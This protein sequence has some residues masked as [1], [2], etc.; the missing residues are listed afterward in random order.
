MLWQLNNGKQTQLSHSDANF[1]TCRF[2]VQLYEVVDSVG[3]IFF[4]PCADGEEKKHDFSGSMKV[5]IQLKV[6]ERNVLI[7]ASRNHLV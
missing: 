3:K 5:L 4:F 2:G 1:Q 7:T 6:R